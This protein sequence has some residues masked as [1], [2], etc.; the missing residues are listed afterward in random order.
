[1]VLRCPSGTLRLTLQTQPWTDDDAK[2][3][4]LFGIKPIRVSSCRVYHVITQRGRA[5]PMQGHSH[6]FVF[7]LDFSFFGFNERSELHS[8]VLSSNELALN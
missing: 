7:K 4:N 3:L 1:M 2:S 5:A 6:L 8:M